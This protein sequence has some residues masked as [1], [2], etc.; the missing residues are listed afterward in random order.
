MK[1]SSQYPQFKRAPELEKKLLD[2]GYSFDDIAR[3]RVSDM[4]NVLKPF[5]V[6]NRT[7]KEVKKEDVEKPMGLNDLESFQ[8]LNRSHITPTPTP[9]PSSSSSS[10]KTLVTPTP[11]PSSSAPLLDLNLAY[12][13]NLTLDDVSKLCGQIDGLKKL[14]SFY[15]QVTKKADDLETE[16]KNKES[17]VSSPFFD[18]ESRDIL[19]KSMT[20][21]YKELTSIRK[22]LFTLAEHFQTIITNR[23][24]LI[25]KLREDSTARKQLMDKLYLL[26]I[27]HKNVLTRAE[28]LPSQAIRTELSK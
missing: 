16:L 22:W 26:Q 24:T 15:S 21:E 14:Q 9:T 11:P 10:K 4:K 18:Y 12:L 5:G 1:S 3:M 13:P 17:M 8:L 7:E 2:L 23:E 25:R 27:F 20:D 6:D 28:C 19:V